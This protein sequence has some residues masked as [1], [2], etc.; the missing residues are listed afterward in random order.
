MNL[1]QPARAGSFY[2]AAPTSCKHHACNLVEAV[3]VDPGLPK[4]V[5]GGLVPHAGWVYSGPLAAKTLKT[6]LGSGKVHTVVLFGADHCG[7]VRTG[8]VYDSGVWRTPMGDV[9]IDE[10]LA[11]A[12]IKAAPLLLRANPEAH[13]NEHS[14]EVQIPLLQAIDPAIKIVPIGVPPNEHAAAIGQA[15]GK[16][17]ASEFPGAVVVGSSDLTHHGGHMAQMERKTSVER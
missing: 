10:T 6:L 4:T 11:A 12:I 3:T 8:E 17:L 9:P 2:E 16:V 7:T 13:K 5:Y 15:V 1:R 14:L